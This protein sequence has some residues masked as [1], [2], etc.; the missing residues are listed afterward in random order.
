VID[1]WLSSEDD[2]EAK[3]F[4][5]YHHFADRLEHISSWGTLEFWNTLRLEIKQWMKEEFTIVDKYG[6]P[7]SEDRADFI[8]RSAKH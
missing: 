7:V 8:M 6:D 2:I 1:C 4:G 5:F 3:L